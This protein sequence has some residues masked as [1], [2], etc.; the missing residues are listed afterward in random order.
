MTG[1]HRL[2]IRHPR[3]AFPDSKIEELSR[4]Y[5]PTLDR[6]MKRH[7]LSSS[8]LTKMTADEKPNLYALLPYIQLLEVADLGALSTDGFQLCHFWLRYC[9]NRNLICRAWYVQVDRTADLGWTLTLLLDDNTMDIERLTEQLWEAYKEY[10]TLSWIP[11][12][13][14]RHSDCRFEDNH[15]KLISAA[16]DKDLRE[17]VD[18]RFSVVPRLGDVFRETESQQA[19]CLLWCDTNQDTLKW[20]TFLL[21]Y[22]ERQR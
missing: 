4:L 22:P 19:T 9:M 11:G 1:T 20:K 13:A 5:S 14:D 6:I 17:L 10:F 3:V 7:V 21:W 12:E 15:W 8:M 2:T 18:D 16:I